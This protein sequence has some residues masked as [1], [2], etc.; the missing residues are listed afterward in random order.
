MPVEFKSSPK[1]RH[2]T[3]VS[4]LKIWTATG[5]GDRR[6][7][8]EG[9]LTGLAIRKRDRRAV[10]VTNMHVLTGYFRSRLPRNAK[11]YHSQRGSERLPLLHLYHLRGRR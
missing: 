6:K 4:G 8:G 11:M 2:D 10:L 7:I 3:L 1:H 5:T 9:T